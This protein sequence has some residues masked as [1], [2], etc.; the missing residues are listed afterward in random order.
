MADMGMMRKHIKYF[1]EDNETIRQ[2]FRECLETINDNNLYM[3]RKACM[4][5]SMVYVFML[6]ISKLLLPNFTLSKAHLAVVPLMLVYFNINLYT[7]K[8][9]G[10]IGTGATAA[11]CCTFYFCLGVVL[12]VVDVFE[13][14][15]GQALW[16]PLA[17]IGLP[18][19]FIDRLYK[20][21]IEELVV[22]SIMLVMSFL[23]KERECF[24]RDLY[25]SIAAYVISMLAAR[26]ILEMR[27][28]ETLAIAEVTRLSSLD[29]LTHVF[30]KGALVARMETYY[31]KRSAD[32]PCAM[33]IIDIDDFK[34]VNDN[35][36][37]NTGDLL[38]ERIG[39]L[40]GENFRA[41]DIVGR[42]G[43]DEFVVVMPRMG[44]VNILSSRC[45]ALQSYISELDYGNKNPFTASIGAV[46]S[47]GIPNS[48]VIFEM[49][50]D[51]LYK[52]KMQ[53]KNCCTIW[54]YEDREIDRPVLLAVTESEDD[55]MNELRSELSSRFHIIRADNDNKALYYLSRYHKQIEFAVIKIN[56]RIDLGELVLKYI[57][58]REGFAK[59]PVLAVTETK[60]QAIIA[61]KLQADEALEVEAPDAVYKKTVQKLIGM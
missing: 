31:A 58:T 9:R 24:I 59:I 33:C 57:K 25:I 17:V 28:R 54:E 60:S 21:G 7:M 22:L 42:Y 2:Y 13:V 4:Y 1:R 50:D 32:E 41:Y 40:L 14:P 11:I 8:H 39:R 48:S 46:I 26:I 5:M 53:G 15:A 35:L 61:K 55:K 47:T 30:N 10:Q 19:I 12:G 44:D 18:M 23:H 49:A 56:D 29:K 38:L 27:A 36:G 45:K 34:Y 43:G 20:Y 52:S 37:H 3:L 51:A 6:I 16:L